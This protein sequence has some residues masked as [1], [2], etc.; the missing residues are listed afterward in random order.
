[1]WASQ[2][3]REH[4]TGDKKIHHPIVGDLDLSFEGMEPAT[5]K[6]L[7]LTAYTAKPGT[8]SHDGLQMLATW[9]ATNDQTA[10]EQTAAVTTDAPKRD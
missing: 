3:V 4:R 6:G 10:T 1:M 2:V 5:G 7:L 8:P 9:A